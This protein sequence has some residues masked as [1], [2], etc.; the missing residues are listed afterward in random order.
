M[1]LVLPLEKI[2]SSS[3]M[4]GC[5]TGYHVRLGLRLE[6]RLLAYMFIFTVLFSLCGKR[7]G[8]WHAC[9]LWLW[10]TRK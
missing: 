7:A 6:P 4:G 5:H 8:S 2:S 1:H 3:M 9:A 10:A